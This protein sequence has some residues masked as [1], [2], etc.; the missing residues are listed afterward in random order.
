MAFSRS[1]SHFSYVGSAQAAGRFHQKVLKPASE[2]IFDRNLIRPSI[3][4]QRLGFCM[5]RVRPE[6]AQRRDAVP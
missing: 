6:T 5:S 1:E 2:P 4:L 3:V